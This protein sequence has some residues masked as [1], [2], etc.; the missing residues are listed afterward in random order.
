MNSENN[1]FNNIATA[2][3]MEI[4]KEEKADNSPY[5]ENISLV[6]EAQKGNKDAEE[7]LL[8]LNER[9]V[10]SVA[11]KFAGRTAE[12]EDIFQLGCLGLL[13]AV[14]SF[15]VS[16]NTAFSTYA[17]PLIFGEIRRYLR[18]NGPIKVSRE[19]KRLGAMLL[20]ENERI[21]KESGREPGI[22]ELSSNI[23]V[24]KERAAAALSAVSPIISFSEPTGDDEGLTLE[25]TLQADDT[26]EKTI[27]RTALAEAVKKLSPTHRK[28]LYYRYFRDLSQCKTAELLSLTQVK[29]S[30]EEKKLLTLLREELT[31]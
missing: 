10:R 11:A 29:I 20:R 25:S 27:E 22:E 3:S 17:V 1:N 7:K 9:L 8:L 15:D 30:R 14:R 12:T 18:D 23:G 6:I 21:I 4:E 2:D 13:K 24:S 26:S 5:G 19:E 28:I 31:V 16:R